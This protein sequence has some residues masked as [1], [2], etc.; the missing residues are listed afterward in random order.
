MG[1]PNIGRNVN[2]V[3]LT[4]TATLGADVEL[5]IVNATGGNFTATLTDFED[6]AFHQ[7]E[8]VLDPADTSGNN[9]TISGNAGVFT[10]SISSDGATSCILQ[11]QYDGTWFVVGDVSSV[12]AAAANSR[13]VSAGTQA[14]TADSKAVS[15]S[16]TTSTADSKGVSNS[17]VISTLT[18]TANSKDTSQSVLISTADSQNTSQ[19]VITST[20]TTTTNSHIASL[21]VNLSVTTSTANSG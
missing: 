2:Q 3:S 10:T 4:T 6:N 12:D 1:I 16:I 5:A 17:V 13:A 19:S 15:D 8:F 20:L 7:V 14:S 11:T 9:V 18:T 21:S